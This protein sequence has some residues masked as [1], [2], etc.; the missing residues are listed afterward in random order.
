MVLVLYIPFYLVFLSLQ[1]QYFTVPI[2][3]KYV[4]VVDQ[5]M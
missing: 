5:K 3:R 4:D 1:L 2:L